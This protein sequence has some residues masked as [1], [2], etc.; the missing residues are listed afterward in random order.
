LTFQQHDYVMLEPFD[1][2][3]INSA[4]HLHP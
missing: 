2:L 1:R 4:K 3:R